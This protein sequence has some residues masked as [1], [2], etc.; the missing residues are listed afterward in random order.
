M[1]ET[2]IRHTWRG[3]EVFCNLT[4][5]SPLS[6]FPVLTGKLYGFAALRTT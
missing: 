5:A 1:I 6:S 3:K 4:S 2:L